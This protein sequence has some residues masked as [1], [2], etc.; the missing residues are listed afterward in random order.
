MFRR[1][2]DLASDFF[3]INTFVQ[4]L[5][6]KSYYRNIIA[7]DKVQ[8]MADLRAGF[9]VVCRSNDALDSVI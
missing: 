4:L 8:A 5:V 6:H 2:D 9:W 7:T 3:P 1:P